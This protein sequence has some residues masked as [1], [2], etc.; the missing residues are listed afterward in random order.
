MNNYLINFVDIF[1]C[2]YFNCT[3]NTRLSAAIILSTLSLLVLKIPYQF[4]ALDLK[5]MLILRVHKSDK[6]ELV[7]VE[8]NTERQLL[9]L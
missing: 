9:N 8:L 3:R 7:L 5:Y 2:V 6:Y 4:G 1:S